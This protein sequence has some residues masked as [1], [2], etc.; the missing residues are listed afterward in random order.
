MRE[1]GW[2]LQ[3]AGNTTRKPNMRRWRGHMTWV[4]VIFSQFFPIL[5]Q[6]L[7]LLQL[8]VF[9]FVQLYSNWNDTRKPSSRRRWKE[10]MTWFSL[11]DHWE[12]WLI[13]C[14]EDTH[15]AKI[16]FYVMFQIFSCQLLCYSNIHWGNKL[17][18]KISTSWLLLF[19]DV[20]ANPAPAGKTLVG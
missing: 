9:N 17:S 5:S 11:L 15:I 12:Q 14:M 18:Q 20:I 6:L 3:R 2:V 8:F 19:L 10:H 4:L 7:F 13:V 16:D 1:V